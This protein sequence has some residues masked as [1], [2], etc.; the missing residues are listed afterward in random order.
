M[1]RIVEC[2]DRV[3]EMVSGFVGIAIARHEYLNGCTRLTIQPPVNKDGKLP[4]DET[5]DE[6][7]LKVTKRAAVKIGP[8][9]T[10][11]PERYMPKPRTTGK[12]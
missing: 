6:P 9:D 7:Q 1:L 10:G 2:G 5:F 4:K 12:R 8:R 3:K 11:G